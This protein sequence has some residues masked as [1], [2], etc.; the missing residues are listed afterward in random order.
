[1]TSV[2]FTNVR[3]FDGTGTL[4]YPG[5]VL[6]QGNRISRISRGAQALPTAGVVTI[7]GGGATLMPGLVEA[8]TH[9]SWNDQP[10]LSEIQRMPTSGAPTSPSATSTWASLIGVMKDGVLPKDPQ[11]G[12][13]RGRFSRS[14]A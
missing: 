5:E 8:H 3:I 9:F 4:S 2:L 10:G 12:P 14:A 13:A 1:M 11:E 6:V 7:D